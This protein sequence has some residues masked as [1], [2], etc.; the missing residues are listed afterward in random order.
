MELI[1]I[2]SKHITT[3]I[4]NNALT[5]DVIEDDQIYQCEINEHDI[6][7]PFT[8][9]ILADNIHDNFEVNHEY[10]R[11]EFNFPVTIAN[12]TYPAGLSYNYKTSYLISDSE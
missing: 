12:K 6:P 3:E 10:R 4:I 8:C 1:Q 11:F 2:G 9:Q 7:S 5:I